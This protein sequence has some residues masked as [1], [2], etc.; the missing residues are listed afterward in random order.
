MPPRA[1]AAANRA[2]VDEQSAIDLER[3]SAIVVSFDE[4]NCIVANFSWDFIFGWRVAVE[5]LIQLKILWTKYL[6]AENNR[7]YGTHAITCTCSVQQL[8]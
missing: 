3:S 6:T 2:R 4:Q 8:I 5:N 7:L 1:V